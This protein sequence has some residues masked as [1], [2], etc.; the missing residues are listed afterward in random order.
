MSLTAKKKLK[1]KSRSRKKPA[2]VIRRGGMRFL[3]VGRIELMLKGDYGE[4]R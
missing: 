1:T 4:K 2:R 3:K